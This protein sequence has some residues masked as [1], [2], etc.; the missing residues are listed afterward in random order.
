MGK[1]LHINESTKYVGG[2]PLDISQG[3]CFE[4]LDKGIILCRRQVVHDNLIE[5]WM[6]VGIHLGYN[7][8]L[9]LFPNMMIM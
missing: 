9:I 7:L 3:I 1:Q 6:Q 4:D 8:N 2:K 5:A